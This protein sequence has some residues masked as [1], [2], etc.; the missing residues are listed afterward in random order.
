M[1][2]SGLPSI[3]QL[4]MEDITL[5]F[6]FRRDTT[7]FLV[8]TLQW[9][10]QGPPWSDIW[11]PLWPYFLP[12]PFLCVL[13]SSHTDLPVLTQ[14]H[15]TCFHLRPQSLA[16]HPLEHSSPKCLHDFFFSIFFGSLLTFSVQNKKHY[17]ACF[18]ALYKCYYILL[19]FFIL[20][21]L[22]FIQ[23]ATFIYVSFI[24]STVFI[25][26]GKASSIDSSYLLW[27]DV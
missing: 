9:H 11:L 21:I 27:M 23:V 6:I 10:L 19:F 14:T 16:F 18:H 5:D 24:L 3:P 17:F 13:Y 4:S 12:F 22:K 25:P 2:I 1:A 7:S 8:K 20:N 26:F 15:Q